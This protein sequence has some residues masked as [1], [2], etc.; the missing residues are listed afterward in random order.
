MRPSES[1]P[2]KT[3]LK[4][5]IAA[6]QARQANGSAAAS[7]SGEKPS[8][9][10][11]SP[12]P[13][14]A[15]SPWATL[16][17]IDAISPINPPVQQQTAQPAR[18][19]TQDAR[20]FEQPQP[21][22]VPAREIAADTFDRS[23]REGEG[24]PRELFNSANGRYE[25]APEGRRNSRAEPHRKP[26]LLQRPSHGGPAEPS[27]AF[28]TRRRGSSVSQGSLPPGRRMSMSRPDMPPTSERERRTSTVIGHDMRGSP[29]SARNEPARP[30]FAQQSAW[31]QQMPPQP[32]EG[33][34][35]EDP[36]K[37]QERIMR[38][39][40]EEAKRRREEEE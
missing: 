10:A 5:G 22:T 9:K 40:R 34:P 7:P 37:V 4:P 24:T 1:G 8:L 26:S 17:P 15:R 19:P 14:P 11:K 35:A 12:A 3:I 21:S 2:P 39:K 16:P 18:L 20:A 33:E 23:W 30:Q 32:E 6:Q 27:S 25:P 28:Q 38:E 13:A 31:D 29:S 36:V